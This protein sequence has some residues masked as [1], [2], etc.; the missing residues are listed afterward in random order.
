MTDR[1]QPI[2]PAPLTDEQRANI[3]RAFREGD[4]QLWRNMSSDN[5]IEIWESV[6]IAC[7]LIGVTNDQRWQL[8]GKA[9][10]EAA[11][12]EADEA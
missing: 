6:R 11:E 12:A 5:R 3:A 7:S 10:Y 1:T 9:V 2:E 8:I 4:R